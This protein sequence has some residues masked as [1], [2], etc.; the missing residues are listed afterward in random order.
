MLPLV[1]K[2]GELVAQ[3]PDVQMALA[4]YGNA[5]TDLPEYRRGQVSAPVQT[6]TPSGSELL[7]MSKEEQREASWKALST[8]QGRRS[9]TPVVNSLVQSA[10]VKMGFQLVDAVPTTD[11]VS[12]HQW[13]VDLSSGSSLQ[14]MFSYMDVAGKALAI[15]LV[16]ELKNRNPRPVILQVTN[17]DQLA[18]RRVGWAAR[19]YEIPA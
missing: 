4:R 2:H 6:A 3:D 14:P 1:A 11:A 17:L 5:E 15:G 19:L 8:T 7:V 9:A 12:E 13:V 18:D 16:R 10:L